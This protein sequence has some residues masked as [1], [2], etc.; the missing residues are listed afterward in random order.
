MKKLFY[1]F[2]PAL[3]TILPG[4]DRRCE[5]GSAFDDEGFNRDLTQV[6]NSFSSFDGATRSYDLA[7]PDEW[8]AYM[9]ELEMLVSWLQNI[10]TE[11]GISEIVENSHY[12]KHTNMFSQLVAGGFSEAECLEFINANATPEFKRMYVQMGNDISQYEIGYIIENSDLLPNEKL[13]FT[14]CLAMYNDLTLGNWFTRGMSECDKQL[15]QDTLK[16]KDNTAVSMLFW[17]G[18]GIFVPK[19]GSGGAIVGIGNALIEEGKCI[20][21]AIVTFNKCRANSS[22]V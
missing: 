15:M 22:P 11:Y 17:I 4:C 19:I 9:E 20:D 2:I 1:L 13:A 5:R 16:C 10:A 14:T 7:D 8:D 21:A 6:Y 12:Y 3:F 18:V